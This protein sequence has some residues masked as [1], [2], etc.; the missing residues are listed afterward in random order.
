MLHEQTVNGREKGTRMGRWGRG[1]RG[2]RR[3]WRRR[4]FGFLGRRRGR[5]RRCS[6][7]FGLL[8]SSRGCVLLRWL[9]IGDV[10]PF[11]RE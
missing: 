4:R 1:V 9:E 10:V 5:G 2:F 6:S 7:R 11:L 8:F 3:V